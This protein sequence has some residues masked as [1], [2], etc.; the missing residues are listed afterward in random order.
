MQDTLIIE[1]TGKVH[2][3]PNINLGNIVFS[4]GQISDDIC[5]KWARPD[6]DDVQDL[7][8]EVASFE[9]AGS[10]YED[11]IYDLE[12][13]IN[14]AVKILDNAFNNI[15]EDKLMDEIDDVLEVLG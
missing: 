2:S 11:K 6:G 5:G 3:G 7:K 14:A 15:D 4:D 10:D 9:N 1:A 13:K 12:A 8:A